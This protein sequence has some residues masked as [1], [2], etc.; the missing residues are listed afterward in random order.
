MRLESTLVFVYNSFR[1]P[2]FQNLVFQ[3]LE[4]LAEERQ[5]EFHLITY[6]QEDYRIEGS[7]MEK[8]KNELHKKG[9]YWYPLSYAYGPVLLLNKFR[10]LIDAIRLTRRIK[11]HH[12]PS[13]IL[14]FG[15]VAAAFSGLLSSLFKFKSIIIQYE[16]HSLFL[17]ELGRWSKS[18]LKFQVLHQLEAFAT[19]RTDYIMTGTQHMIDTLKNRGVKS[20]MFRTPN[21]VDPD[22]MK[23]DSEARQEIRKSLE[24]EG[25]DVF[26]Y[27]GK[28]G[29]LYY[30]KELIDV[31]S[32]L[33]EKN[34]QAHF[35]IITGY[36]H[37]KLMGW[38]HELGIDRTQYTLLGAVPHRE[39]PRYLSAA[40]LGM[41]AIPPTPAQKYR[42]PLK[43][44]DYLYCGLPYL[45]CRGVSEDDDYAEKY[46]IGVTLNAY[47]KEEL[48]ANYDRIQEL[49]LENSD[50]RRVRCRKVGLEY[51]DKSKV[52]MTLSGILEGSD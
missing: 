15:N 27:I 31:C 21:A 45:V 9:I 49:L 10:N 32:A 38:F 35:L 48:N 52:L 6:E 19:G 40:D 51:R 11:K 13:F 1:D 30:E 29:E 47:T 28:L 3:Y 43:T 26:L 7:E 41:V 22:F 42:S 18:S 37:E 39:V 33:A 12:N 24:L 46:N 2:L 36:D 16:P 20:T 23:F 5:A 25:K 14:S 4:E 34:A 50:Q 8:I 17:L 44:A